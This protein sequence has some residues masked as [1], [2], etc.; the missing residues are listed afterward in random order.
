MGGKYMKIAII[1]ALNEEETIGTVV[2]KTKRYVD[3]VIVVDDGSK[4]KTAEVAQLAGAEVV[5]HIENRGKGQ[6]LKTGFERADELAA[7]IVVC[8]DA[9]FQHNPDDIPT[10]IAPIL[11][12][13]ADM[14]IGSRFLNKDHKK[15]IPRY[16]RLGQ[17]ILTTTTNLDSDIK[18]TDSQSGFRAFSK[19]ILRKFKFGQKG[20]SI[21][22]EMIKDAMDN[23]IKIKEVPI[24]M[25]YEGLETSTETPGKHGWGVL[26]YILKIVM[27]K[28]PLLV[29]GISGMILLIIGLV[30]GLYSIDFYFANNF[31]PFGPYFYDDQRAYAIEPTPRRKVT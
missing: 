22:S 2:I 25:R 10:V 8:I 15:D 12:G 5:S 27:E 26:N 24:S 21:E 28:R 11:E 30:F 17:W 19:D 4:D 3:K 6:A 9:D 29:F 18:I 13:E 7:D 1:A 23:D 31:V 14:V 16:R 20:L